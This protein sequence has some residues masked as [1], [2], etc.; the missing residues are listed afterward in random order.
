MTIAEV[1]AVTM[2]ELRERR[3]F[4]ATDGLLLMTSVSAVVSN[5]FFATSRY[6]PVSHKRHRWTS[7]CASGV[8]ILV[9]LYE[10]AMILSNPPII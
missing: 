5:D 10:V 6:Y 8:A 7:V 9:G 4:D 2:P 3:P 1:E